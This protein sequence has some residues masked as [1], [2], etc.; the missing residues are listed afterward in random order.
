MSRAAV[1]FGAL[2]L[3]GALAVGIGA[4]VQA[5]APATPTPTPSGPGPHVAPPARTPDGLIVPTRTVDRAP[6]LPEKEKATVIV[7][8]RDGAYEAYLLASGDVDGFVRSLPPGDRLAIAAA[9][10]ALKA[11]PPRVT[12]PPT[13]A[14]VAIPTAPPVSGRQAAELALAHRDDGRVRARG[15]V[16]VD[17]TFLVPAREVR[18]RTGAPTGLP[19]ARPVYLVI[20]RGSFEGPDPAGRAGRRSAEAAYKVL[21]PTTGALLFDALALPRAYPAPAPGGGRA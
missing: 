21:D 17:S 16:E 18:D 12:P 19:D 5:L 13:S 15:P 3:L 11:S 2:L 1:A 7:Q 9:P 20:L 8:R 4:P 14:A 6:H 10:P